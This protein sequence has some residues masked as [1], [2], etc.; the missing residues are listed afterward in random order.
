MH[1]CKAEGSKKAFNGVLINSSVS[2]D[3]ISIQ[4]E[5]IIERGMLL[6]KY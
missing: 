4:L 2:I 6:K 3:C 5:A 1:C